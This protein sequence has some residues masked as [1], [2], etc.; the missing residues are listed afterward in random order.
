[1]RTIKYFCAGFGIAVAMYFLMLI[2][3]K[4]MNWLIR[5][6]VTTSIIPAWLIMGIIGGIVLTVIFWKS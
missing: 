3:F 2:M 1:M 5:Q 6:D 4:V